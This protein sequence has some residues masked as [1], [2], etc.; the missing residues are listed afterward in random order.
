MVLIKLYLEKETDTRHRA[1]E[2]FVSWRCYFLCQGIQAPCSGHT[3]SESLDH[4]VSPH[5]KLS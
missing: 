2:I 3:E 1:C 5:L 4:Q